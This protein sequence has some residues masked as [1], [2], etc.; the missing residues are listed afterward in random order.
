MR[1]RPNE[2]QNVFFVVIG[3]VLECV[4]KFGNA[5][6]CTSCRPLN[7]AGVVAT[8]V[9]ICS[10]TRDLLYSAFEHSTAGTNPAK[11]HHDG[12]RTG[13]QYANGAPLDDQSVSCIIEVLCRYIALER[14]THVLNSL[15]YECTNDRADAQM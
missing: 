14:N 7:S 9:V 13:R 6:G 5:Y 12:A 11:A 1:I 4:S 8:Q 10:I 3:V 2:C 15:G